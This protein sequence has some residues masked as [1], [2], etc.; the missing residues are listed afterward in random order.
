MPLQ[1]HK[2][3]WRCRRSKPLSRRLHETVREPDS[4][5]I[6]QNGGAWIVNAQLHFAAPQ[7]QR[8]PPVPHQN[9]ILCVLRRPGKARL[10]STTCESAVPL[11]QQ[12]AMRPWRKSTTL[13][14]RAHGP[15]TRV[16]ALRFGLEALLTAAEEAETN[17]F[18]ARLIRRRRK[19]NT[20][21]ATGSPEP[22]GTEAG[23]YTANA[24]HGQVSNGDVFAEH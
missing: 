5:A 14:T 12:E 6:R 13:S 4:A 2:T 17:A 11:Q 24:E 20:A 22:P 23:Q 21:A 8:R 18:L 15:F 9:N 16:A 3:I 19:G 7:L 10:T 1:Q